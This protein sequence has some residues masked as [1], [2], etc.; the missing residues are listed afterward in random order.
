MDAYDLSTHL[1][2]NNYCGNK[3][4]SNVPAAAAARLDHS[5]IS[6]YA[7]STGDEESRPEEGDSF[8]YESDDA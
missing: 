3:K 5:N 8:M 7:S 6:G 4:N 2:D 1:R